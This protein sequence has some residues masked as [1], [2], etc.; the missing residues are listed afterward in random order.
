[1]KNNYTHIDIL[2][3]K[4]GKYG[5]EKELLS[6]LKGKAWK[7]FELKYKVGLPQKVVLKYIE[8]E[9]EN[10]IPEIYKPLLYAFREVQNEINNPKN[11]NSK[12]EA[13]HKSNSQA[14][15]LRGGRPKYP[16]LTKEKPE[17]DPNKKR[18][19]RIPADEM[20]RRIEEK[21]AA[22]KK[23]Q[24]EI[25][26]KKKAEAIERRRAEME[27]KAKAEAEKKEAE[28]KA[29]E[30]KKKEEAARLASRSDSFKLD[31]KHVEF[32][33]GKMI[34]HPYSPLPTPRGFRQFN[35]RVVQNA[36]CR[37]GFNFI[38][39]YL[40]KKLP[41]IKCFVN[42]NKFLVFEDEISLRSAII[43]ISKESFKDDIEVEETTPLYRGFDSLS[44]D[45]AMTRANELSPAE[46]RKFKS[47]FIDYLVSKQDANSKIAPC[48]EYIRN[49]N[50]E[51]R[52]DGFFFTI[53]GRS[54]NVIVYENL[55]PDRATLFFKVEKETYRDSLRAIF[56]FLTSNR[57]NKRMALKEKAVHLDSHGVLAYG[58]NYHTTFEEWR[59][60][61]GKIILRSNI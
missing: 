37:K 19:P 7:Y 43:Q 29:I 4:L 31:W 17:I 3:S 58:Y 21:K 30:Q 2:V 39:S 35:E 20:K 32:A 46:F 13:S 5:A 10:S 51:D 42:I 55:N 22:E 28:L 34:I 52:E 25:L 33:Y 38:K 45:R 36:I 49:T 6:T 18:R 54:A 40:A 41:P 11:T 50:S 44:F 8:T 9:N 47:K 14:K 56:N 26:G 60:R 1:M 57:I 27:A 15:I 24:E 48:S 59:D 12:I 16:T 53:V 23:S 61:M